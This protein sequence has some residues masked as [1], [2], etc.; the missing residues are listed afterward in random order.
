MHEQEII[1]K[2]NLI[3]NRLNNLDYIIKEI[4]RKVTNIANI[5]SGYGTKDL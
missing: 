4:D 2:L 1:A 3:E 5:G